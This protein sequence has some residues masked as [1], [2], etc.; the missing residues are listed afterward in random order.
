MPRT[1][2]LLFPSLRKQLVSIGERLRLARLRR[3]YSAE[4]V[5]ARANIT[6]V[7]LHRVE[8]GEPSVA[9]GTYASVLQ[10]LGLQDDLNA[11]ALEDPLGRKLQDLNL[12]TR[13]SRAHRKDADVREG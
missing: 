7:T 2:P 6:R 13:Q 4:M 9:L 3:K 12:P 1:S 5:A 10:V 11:I 8:K